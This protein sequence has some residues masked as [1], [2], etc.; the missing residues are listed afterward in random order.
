[1]RA[2]GTPARGWGIRTILPSGAGWSVPAGGRHDDDGGAPGDPGDP[3]VVQRGGRRQQTPRVMALS[4][5]TPGPP[6]PVT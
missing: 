5:T 1:V 3:A 6:T 2:R 4:L